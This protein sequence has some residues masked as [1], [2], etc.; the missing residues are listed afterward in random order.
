MGKVVNVTKLYEEWLKEV[1]VDLT[2]H[3]RRAGDMVPPVLLNLSARILAPKL[4]QGNGG[5]SNE[6]Q[7]PRNKSQTET[8]V[9]QNA[10][11]H[12]PFCKGQQ[13]SRYCPP[14]TSAGSWVGQRWKAD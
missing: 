5:G 8:E 2:T 6:R 3:S 10:S 14:A 9:S 13:D 7:T 11:A 4:S 12:I 1:K